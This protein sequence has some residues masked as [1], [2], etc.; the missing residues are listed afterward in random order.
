MNFTNEPICYT[1]DMFPYKLPSC[2]FKNSGS[3]V[4]TLQFDALKNKLTNEQINICIKNG[5]PTKNSMP[6]HKVPAAKES[7]S[8]GQIKFEK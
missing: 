4:D 7:I 3:P 6:E 8:P 1:G 5:F 2:V